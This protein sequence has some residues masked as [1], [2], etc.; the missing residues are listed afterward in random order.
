[1]NART[2]H[3]PVQEE[4]RRREKLR[5][6]NQIAKLKAD[7][8]RRKG[9]DK[10][11]RLADSIGHH[12]SRAR[13]EEREQRKMLR[14]VEVF[15]AV[16]PLVDNTR[17]S[18]VLTKQLVDIGD[19]AFSGTDNRKLLMRAARVAIESQRKVNSTVKVE[20]EVVFDY[21]PEFD[22]SS[23]YLQLIKHDVLVVS[24]H[25]H[26]DWWVGYSLAAPDAVGFFPASYVNKVSCEVT[27]DLSAP[28]GRSLSIDILC[29][30]QLRND[31]PLRDQASNG[32]RKRRRQTWRWR[33]KRMM[34][35]ACLWNT[36][37][38]WPRNLQ[39]AGQFVASCQGR[40]QVCVSNCK[41]ALF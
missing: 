4:E 13:R 6:E 36:F 19:T 29:I 22:D 35:M 14:M 8:D 2:Y 40:R 17:S 25:D 41:L 5:L 27:F 16:A 39:Q 9:M 30:A 28:L 37:K 26:K 31:K 33:P 32:T 10:P 3:I 1:M 34:A 20:A 15:K 23:G 7:R 18:H 24:K 11:L 12:G 21:M 38:R